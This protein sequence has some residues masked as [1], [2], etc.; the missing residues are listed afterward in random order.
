MLFFW[1]E[2]F[3]SRKPIKV[4]LIKSSY[5]LR[6]LYFLLK[7]LIPRHA[8]SSVRRRI[9]KNRLY[10]WLY[11]KLKRQTSHTLSTFHPRQRLMHL[12]LHWSIC[13]YIQLLL[14]FDLQLQVLHNQYIWSLLHWTW[15]YFVLVK[16]RSILSLWVIKQMMGLQRT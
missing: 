16:V 1:V 13:L 8:I 9:L 11:L 14:L 4:H 15:I 3:F 6:I 12:K 2:S 5:L 10:S 7:S